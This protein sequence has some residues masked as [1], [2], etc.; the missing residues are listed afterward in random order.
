MKTCELTLGDTVEVFND[1]PWN[2][3][4]VT[5]IRDGIIHIFRP[6]GCC[7]DFSYTGGVIPYV[8]FEDVTYEVTNS[9]DWKVLERKILKYYALYPFDRK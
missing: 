4:I 7:A 5:Q 6:Y 9:R 2:Y 3:G 1:G 8:G